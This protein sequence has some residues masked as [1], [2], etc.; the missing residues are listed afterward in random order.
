MAGNSSAAGAYERQSTIGVVNSFFSWRRFKITATQTRS[1]STAFGIK[2]SRDTNF[3]TFH[4]HYVPP[5]STSTMDRD[6]KKRKMAKMD[7]RDYKGARSNEI[8]NAQGELQGT[9]SKEIYYKHRWLTFVYSDSSV[10][11]PTAASNS[12]RFPDLPAQLRFRNWKLAEP[13]RWLFELSST[14]G[15]SLSILKD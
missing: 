6:H 2:V 5:Q 10:N 12:T 9:I 11:G 7:E 3:S 13:F 1:Y 15:P 4:S 14:V 8:K